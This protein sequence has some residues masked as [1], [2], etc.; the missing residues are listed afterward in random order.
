MTMIIVMIKLTMLLTNYELF[1]VSMMK[2]T[3]D[4]NYDDKHVKKAPA[5]R[6]I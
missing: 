6:N 4:G 1:I 3:E 2:N 5:Y